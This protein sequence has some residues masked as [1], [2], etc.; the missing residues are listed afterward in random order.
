[1]SDKSNVSPVMVWAE[2]AVELEYGFLPVVVEALDQWDQG[3]RTD[4]SILLTVTHGIKT[5]L[6]PTIEGERMK[7]ATP[8]KKI[9]SI[10]MPDLSYKAD[11]KK[12]S[13][14]TYSVNINVEG[15]ENYHADPA[16][17]RAWLVEIADGTTTIKGEAFKSWLEAGTA[18]KET[19]ART[20]DETAEKAEKDAL[21][22]I[23]AAMDNGYAGRAYA[24]FLLSA[25][26]AEIKKREAEHALA[27]AAE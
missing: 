20:L 22:L 6:V 4:L 2:S 24:N 27:I 3:N 5:T 26:T 14:V 8:L 12:A 13:G 18:P 25:V 23:K 19:P 7:F 9:L 21:R 1:M 17:M 10:V 11:K 16:E 15:D